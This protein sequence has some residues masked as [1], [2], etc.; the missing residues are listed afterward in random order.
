MTQ[1]LLLATSA[2]AFL[3][4]GL[5]FLLRPIEAAASIGLAA[6]EAAGRIDL[7]ATYGGLMLGLGALFALPM[8]RP[9]LASVGPY[10]LLFVYVGLAFG[11]GLAML[12]GEPPV[13]QMVAFLVIELLYVGGAVGLLLRRE[14]TSE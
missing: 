11:R 2:L 7:R 14:P 8:I 3:I 10:L 9:R 6:T 1:R 12:L 4:I 5:L 13:G